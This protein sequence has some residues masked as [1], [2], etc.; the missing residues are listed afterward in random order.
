M[1]G[2]IMNNKRIESMVKEI[3]FQYFFTGAQY[4][5]NNFYGLTKE[6]QAEAIKR[7][8]E[9]NGLDKHPPWRETK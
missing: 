5:P 8:R 7:F 9:R 3:E 6:E 2:R 4:L 1:G